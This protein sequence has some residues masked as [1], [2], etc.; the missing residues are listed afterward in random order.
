MEQIKLDEYYPLLSV[1]D[2][3]CLSNN[4]DVILCYALS[5][6]EIFTLSKEDYSGIHDFWYRALKYLPENSFVHKQDIFIEDKYSGDDLPSKTFLQQSTIKH[7]KGRK[8]FNHT[9]LLFIGNSGNSTLKT[10]GIRNPF[11]SLPK[12]ER[13]LKEFEKDNAFVSEVTKSIEF[14]NSSRYIKAYP[15]YEDEIHTLIQDYYNGFDSEKYVDTDLEE[16]LKADNKTYNAI[17]IGDKRVGLFSINDIKQFPDYVDKYKLDTDYST[18]KFKIYKGA[19]DDFGFKLAF[20]HIYN[21][22]IYIDDHSKH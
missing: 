14:L 20:N 11:K 4:G 7:F 16:K 8:N 15:I 13:I 17:G 6:P 21:Q 9:A 22:I 2:N 12:K 5:L 10:Q 3:I 1:K 18:K 19:A